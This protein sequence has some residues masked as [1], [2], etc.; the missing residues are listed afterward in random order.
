MALPYNQNGEI[1]MAI[2]KQVIAVQPFQLLR[3]KVY[4][5]APFEAK[6]VKGQ[7][8]VDEGKTKIFD[9]TDQD[10]TNSLDQISRKEINLLLTYRH[11][12]RYDT[13]D[14]KKAAQAALDDYARRL[15]ASEIDR[16]HWAAVGQGTVAPT[17]AAPKK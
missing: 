5:I 3:D 7:L 2:P 6:M 17:A 11:V 10:S 16:Q 4:H 14:E 8:E 12:M 1:I 13:T 9:V 15:K